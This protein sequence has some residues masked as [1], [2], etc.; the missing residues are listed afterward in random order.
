MT[1]VAVVLV[2]A[3]PLLAANWVYFNPQV[4][5]PSHFTNHGELLEPPQPIE[6]LSLVT[7][8]GERFGLEQLLHRWTLMYVGD[9]ECDLYCAA[10]LFKTRQVR[11]ALGHDIDRVQRVYLLTDRDATQQVTTLREEHPG[12]LVGTGDA[13]A[14][15]PVLELL[16]SR[17]ED[18]VYLVDPHGNVV[19]RYG[20]ESTS[21]GML[22]DLKKLLKNSRIG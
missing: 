1:L 7:A 16:D 2:F 13:P 14:L 15:S 4:W 9:G 3:V 12:L 18:Y 20:T 19:L 5:T 6:E 22:R 17:T 10:A 21:R 11:L 8:D